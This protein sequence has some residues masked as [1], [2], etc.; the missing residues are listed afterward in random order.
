MWSIESKE[1]KKGSISY[2]EKCTLSIEISFIN[3]LQIDIFI[4]Q[5]IY[6]GPF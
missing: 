3:S 4:S 1:S 6:I 5:I 2:G